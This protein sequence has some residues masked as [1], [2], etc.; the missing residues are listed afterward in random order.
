MQ[1][2]GVK[3]PSSHL[4]CGGTGKGKDGRVGHPELGPYEGPSVF[5]ESIWGEV[6][7]QGL[8]PTAR[9]H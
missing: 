9:P 3:Q 7:L 1:G 2:G 5:T 4:V 6:A 8:P